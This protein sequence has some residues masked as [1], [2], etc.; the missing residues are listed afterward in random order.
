MV[1]STGS[2]LDDVDRK[3]SAMILV[4]GVAVAAFI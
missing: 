3:E 1:S 4:T 2:F